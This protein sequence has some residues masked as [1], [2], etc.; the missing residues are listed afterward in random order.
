[1]KRTSNLTLS[2][3]RGAIIS[4]LYIT[5]TLLTS[6]LGLANGPIQFR[7]SEAL[8]IL[9]LFLPEAVPGLFF[10][11]LISNLIIPGGVIWDIIFGSAATLIGALGARAMRGIPEKFKWAAALPTILANMIIIPAVLAFTYGEAKVYWY[12]MLTVGGGEVICGGFGGSALYYLLK[13]HEKIWLR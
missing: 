9:P 10:G 12:F 11:C 6:V 7:I 13:K 4:A 2:T 8:C 3:A 1:M 5:L